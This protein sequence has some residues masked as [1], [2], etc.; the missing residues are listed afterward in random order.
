MREWKICFGIIQFP[1]GRMPQY[2]TSLPGT[3]C[4]TNTI[5]AYRTSTAPSAKVKWLDWQR[6][7][8]CNHEYKSWTPNEHLYLYLLKCDQLTTK[9]QCSGVRDKSTIFGLLVILEGRDVQPF[10]G[11]LQWIHYWSSCLTSLGK[12][13]EA[14][15]SQ[16][17][18]PVFTVE[19]GAQHSQ[20]NSTHSDYFTVAVAALNLMQ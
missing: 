1:T 17:Q 3:R 7:H 12:G 15:W 9:K 2:L 20:R 8:A 6:A 5:W 10:Q 16:R 14:I 4:C 18:A 11:G 19:G 13:R